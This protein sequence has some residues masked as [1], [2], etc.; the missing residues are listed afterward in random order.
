MREYKR[1]KVSEIKRGRHYVATDK[2]HD[3]AK[4]GADRK[5]LS[6]SAY[7]VELIVKDN[8]DAS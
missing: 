3:L 1:K 2:E 4:K 8:D 7:I 6:V 5:G